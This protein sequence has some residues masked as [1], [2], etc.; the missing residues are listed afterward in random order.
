MTMAFT[1]T[2][3]GTRRMPMVARAAYLISA[4]HPNPPREFG[5]VLGWRAL[6]K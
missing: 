1:A 5:V 2:R 3:S 6:I 4:L